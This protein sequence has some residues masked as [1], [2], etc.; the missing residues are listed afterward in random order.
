MI[1]SFLIII[2]FHLLL[3]SSQQIV[4]VVADDFNATTANM[5]CFEN[6]KAVYYG[7]KVNI[8]KNGLGWGL[9]LHS[10]SQK[11][12]EPQKKEGDKKA[13]AGVFKL[14]SI[15]GYK[16]DG[17]YQMPY[18]YASA[19]L[20]CVDDITSPLYNK[21]II[22]DSS[23]PKSY[24]KI[25]RDD[26]LYELGIVVAHNE[27]G[28][29]QRGSCIFMHVQRG[30]NQPTVGCTSMEYKNLK[31]IAHWLDAKKNP[32]LIEIPKS[33][34]KEVLKLYPQLKSSKLLTDPRL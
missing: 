32:I 9:G 29:K 33:S 3:F 5:E 34:T 7:I 23:L 12:Q 21:I 16:E 18:L 28:V 17:Q 13:P 27:K 11:P 15:F 25:R 4:L 10:L 22:L 8:G 19:N 31:K 20:I 26:D 30:E 14:T 6:D 1:K 2:S 24:E